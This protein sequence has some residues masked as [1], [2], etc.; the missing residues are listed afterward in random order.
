MKNAVNHSERAHASLSASGAS[1]WLA[2]PPSVRL[3]EQYEET[4]SVFAREGTFMHELSELYLSYE[5]KQMTKAQLNKKLKQMKQNEFYNAEIEQAV[6]TYVDFATEKMN[7]A[8]ATSKDPLILIEEKVDFSPW[9]PA[10][11]GTGDIILIYGDRLEVIDLKGGK[12]VKVS[13][14]EN[15]QMRLYALGALNNFGL[16][17]DTQKILMTVVQP[18]LDNISTDEMQVDELLEWAEEVVKPKAE[19]AFKGEGDFMAGEHCR[20]CKVKANCRARAEENLKLAC[21][22]FQKPPLLTDDEVVEVL[23][24]MDQLI[25]WAKDVQEYALNMAMD[26]NKQWPG[27]KLVEG[28][29]SRKYSDENAIVEALTTAGYDSDV[30]Y[31][32]S[33]NTI[34]TLEKELGKKTFQELLGSLITKAPGKVKIVPE[35]DKRPEIK[36]SPEVDFQ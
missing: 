28:R 13:A 4:T 32:K 24:S 19:L 2:C 7:E 36:A 10:A 1:R 5:L 16:L 15:P 34:T 17:Y 12:G 21:M 11:F 31:K 23:T 25:S 35:E 8:K 20:F 29:G 3:S 9:V 27:M 18:R 33:L 14:V 6:K 22:D 30:I 26:E